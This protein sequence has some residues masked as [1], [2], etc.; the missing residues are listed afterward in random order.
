M[1]NRPRQLTTTENPPRQLT[2]KENP[3][4]TIEVKYF[5]RPEIVPALRNTIQY[6][7]TVVQN[8]N[9]SY[10]SAEFS[11]QENKIRFSSRDHPGVVH[12]L[13]DATL[14]INPPPPSTSIYGRITPAQQ[15]KLKTM[16]PLQAKKLN[17]QLW[18][19]K[20]FQ[21]NGYEY[22]LAGKSFRKHRKVSPAPKPLKTGRKPGS[23]LHPT[24]GRVR[25]R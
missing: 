20:R 12:V 3:S 4:R 14:Y 8:L 5:L 11:R 19:R 17:A 9:D 22:V 7:D 16:T 10:E 2:T 25:S 21:H 15:Q 23:R 13:N 18:G 6:I 1:S 24:L